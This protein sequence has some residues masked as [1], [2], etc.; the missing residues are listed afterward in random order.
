[1][2]DSTKSPMPLWRRYATIALLAVLIL[3][4]GY[5]VWSKELHHSAANTSAPAP[6]AAPVTRATTKSPAPIQPAKVSTTIPG[7]IPISTRNPFSH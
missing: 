6:A 7:G 5:M 4:S 3:A 1:M 2:I